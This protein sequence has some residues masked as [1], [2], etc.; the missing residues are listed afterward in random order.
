M[1]A[2]CPDA[3][4]NRT[5]WSCV[6]HT[7]TKSIELSVACLEAPSFAQQL[8]RHEKLALHTSSTAHKNDVL[9]PRHLGPK[10]Q[11]KGETSELSRNTVGMTAETS[12]SRN[13]HN[14]GTIVNLRVN[15]RLQDS[16]VE[17]IEMPR[18]PSEN[19]STRPHHHSGGGGLLGHHHTLASKGNKLTTVP[20]RQQRLC[21][22]AGITRTD[23]F[24][25]ALVASH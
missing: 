18:T 14:I 2:V 10:L 11:E 9:A 17:S 25:R 21:A 4:C 7:V 13:M 19:P 6:L 16:N 15:H 20:C 24:P 12:L 22:V 1:P 3:H 8:S 5:A 23:F